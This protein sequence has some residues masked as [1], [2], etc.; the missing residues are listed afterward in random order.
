MMNTWVKSNVFLGFV[1]TAKVTTCNH[2]EAV[3]V[4]HR[5]RKMI[6]NWAHLL[7]RTLLLCDKPDSRGT[8]QAPVISCSFYF[9]WE[10]TSGVTGETGLIR[11]G[12]FNA[13]DFP[14][15]VRGVSHLIKKLCSSATTNTPGSPL[16]AYTP[17]RDT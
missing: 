3:R 4:Q 10:Q 6:K 2:L 13:A 7:V 16:L 12:T 9:G 17:L 5:Q 8:K 15:A 11:T 14:G 1:F